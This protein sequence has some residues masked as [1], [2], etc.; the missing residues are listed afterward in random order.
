METK[1]HPHQELNKAI[2]GIWHGDGTRLHFFWKKFLLF[3]WPFA[4]ELNAD[5]LLDRV[6]DVLSLRT[7][8]WKRRQI[9]R[10][11]GHSASL[12]KEASSF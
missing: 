6:E 10:Y 8:T 11:F 4:N 1:P 12:K 9:V 2:Q 7:A 3:V 5:T